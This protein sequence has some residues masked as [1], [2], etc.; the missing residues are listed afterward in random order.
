MLVQSKKSHILEV[1]PNFIAEL[2][3]QSLNAA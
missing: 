2:T 1:T 3:N